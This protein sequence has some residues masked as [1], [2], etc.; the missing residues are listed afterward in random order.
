MLHYLITALMENL[1]EQKLNI[2]PSKSLNLHTT[3]KKCFFVYSVLS[4]RGI[5]NG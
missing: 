4:L 1:I 5:Q 2:E 3:T